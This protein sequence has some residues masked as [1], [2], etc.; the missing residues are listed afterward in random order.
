MVATAVLFPLAGA[1]LVTVMLLDW[2]VI[3]R[4]KAVKALV[5]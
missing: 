3:S 4:F 2:L 5:S 1:A